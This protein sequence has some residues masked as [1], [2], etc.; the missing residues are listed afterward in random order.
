MKLNK[1]VIIS[2]ILTVILTIIL[3]ISYMAQDKNAEPQMYYQIYLDGEKVGVIENKDYFYNLINQEQ[4]DIK[5]TYQVDQVY[6][7]KGFEI[8]EL[9][10]Y[11]VTPNDPNAIYDEV[12]NGRDFTIRGYSITIRNSSDED[13]SP[14]VVNVINREV[15]E[16]AI[17]KYVTTFVKPETY[18]KYLDNSQD[19]DAEEFLDNIYFEDAISI[20]EAY[21]S[22]SDEI[23]MDS[24]ELVKK[25][26]FGDN[27]E[28]KPYKIKVGDT[29]DDIAYDNKLSVQELLIANDNLKSEDVL[30]AKDEVI[31]IALIDPMLNLTYEMDVEE[32]IDEPYKK[33]LKKTYQKVKKLVFISKEILLTFVQDHT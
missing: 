23:F 32:I 4:T 31:N 17:Q 2:F 5:E 13:A 15:F 27:M 33:E 18:Q 21:I 24:D 7:P 25:L 20:K 8:V 10:A 12:R 29:L 9:I 30:L 26:L 3:V 1:S 28:Y 6:P 14:L 16:E 22:V 19:D 11:N